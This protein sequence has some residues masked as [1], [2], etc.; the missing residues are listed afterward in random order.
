[1]WASSDKQKQA[2]GWLSTRSRGAA[3]GRA[4]SAPADLFRQWSDNQDKKGKGKKLGR[5]CQQMAG[6]V[7]IER[8]NLF[9]CIV[10]MGV[11]FLV[12]WVGMV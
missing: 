2:P 8:H 12:R 6:F 10:R 9:L 5:M 3:A 1:M 11:I 7:E 4:I